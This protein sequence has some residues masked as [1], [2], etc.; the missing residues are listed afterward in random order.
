MFKKVLCVTFPHF[1]LYLS[2][3]VNITCIVI[4]NAFLNS[5][6]QLLLVTLSVWFHLNKKKFC[7]KLQFT[8]KNFNLKLI[9][10]GHWK[11]LIYS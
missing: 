11:L 1:Y 3:D 6:L 7:S 9:M 4:I 10:C 5:P 2:F 8:A